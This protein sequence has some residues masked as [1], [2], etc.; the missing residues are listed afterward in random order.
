MSDNHPLVSI[1][2]AAYNAE[3]WIAEALAS[4]VGQTHPNIE[5]IVVDDGSTDGTLAV[6]R[7]FEGPRVRVIAQ[8]NC[9]ACAARNQAFEESQG[10]YVKF[11]DADDALTPD[12]IATQVAALKG[13]DSNVVS[14]GSLQVCDHELNPVQSRRDRTSEDF[15]PEY[16][17]NVTERV[18]RLLRRNIQTSRPL[19]RRHLVR[20]VGGFDDNLS[21]A[22]EYDFHIRLAL[23]GTRF[24]RVDKIGSLIRVHD[25]PTRISNQSPRKSDSPTRLRE[26]PDWERI[27]EQAFGGEIPPSINGILAR[28]AWRSVRSH[29]QADSIHEAREAMVQAFRFDPHCLHV[30]GKA[31]R[32]FYVH[33]GAIRTERLVKLSK[34]VI[35]RYWTLMES[36]TVF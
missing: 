8:G 1:L 17:D 7:Q 2:V 34:S 16:S 26:H 18:G 19:H 25:S 10:I 36:H 33:L 14:Y 12:A 31:L 22:Q 11:L 15:S 24:K 3:P 5:L 20:A 35:G 13:E 21:R 9:G 23:A 28:G 27:M 4:A 6:A 30:R 29:V 32:L